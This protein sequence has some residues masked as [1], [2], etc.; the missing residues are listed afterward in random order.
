MQHMSEG[1]DCHEVIQYHFTPWPDH[2]VPEYAGPILNYLRSIKVQHKLK[3][4]PILVHC[5]YKLM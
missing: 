1:G 2:G 3:D 5:R 4:G